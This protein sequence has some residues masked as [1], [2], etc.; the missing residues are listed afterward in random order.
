MLA[1]LVLLGQEA[2]T[3]RTERELL[4]DPPSGAAVGAALVL[5]LIGAFTRV[6]A[7]PVPAAGSRRRWSRP[8]R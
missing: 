5:V 4:A 6:G 8:P 2:G 3:Y 1:G 7:V